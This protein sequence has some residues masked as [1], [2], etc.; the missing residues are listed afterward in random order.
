VE[1]GVDFWPTVGK[2]GLVPLHALVPSRFQPR[3]F[4]DPNELSALAETMK[5]GRQREIVTVRELKPEERSSGEYPPEARY[6]IVSGER[7]WRAGKLAG[8]PHIEIRVKVYESDAEEAEDAY[9]LN[10]G[11]VNLTDIENAHALKNLANLHGWET[12]QEVAKKT[13]K[14]AVLV[15]DLFALLKLSPLA[16]SRFDSSLTKREGHFSREVGLFLANMPHEKQDDLVTRMPKDLFTNAQRIGWMSQELKHA[17]ISI[18]T[19]KREPRRMR[20]LVEDLATYIDSKAKILDA[21][22]AFT[23]ILENLPV[24][25]IH[26]FRYKL[27]MAL[28]TFEKLVDR[29]DTQAQ[30]RGVRV[31]PIAPA[32]RTNGGGTVKAEVE[33]H[34]PTFKPAPAPPPVPSGPKRFIEIQRPTFESKPPSAAVAKKPTPPPINVNCYNEKTGRIDFMSFTPQKYVEMM[35]KGYLEYQQLGRSK[36]SHLPGREAA[37]QME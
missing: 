33:R 12:Q 29:V 23:R 19:R 20:E 17:G 31:Q 16:Q 9:M 37:L 30:E 28:K 22:P 21:D 2:P 18:P 13:G 4:F 10:E 8:V 34:V 6:M 14:Q 35:D 1:A 26:A 27:K 32:V 15:S 11:R 24:E 5:G 3:L 36:P 7:R 25:G